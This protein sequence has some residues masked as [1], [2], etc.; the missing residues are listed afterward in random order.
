VRTMKNYVMTKI[1][2]QLVA[3]RSPKVAAH[4]KRVLKNVV[5]ILNMDGQDIAQH[6]AALRAMRLATIKTGMKLA[7]RLSQTEVVDAQKER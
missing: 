6:S 5:R 7:A 1:L 2:T 3:N 4:V